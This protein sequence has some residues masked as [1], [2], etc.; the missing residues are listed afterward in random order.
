MASCV[1]SLLECG[2]CK[3]ASVVAPPYPTLPPPPLKLDIGCG[4]RKQAGFLGVDRIAFAGVDVV[5]DVSA[6]KWPW[7][8]STVDEIHASHFLEHLTASQRIHFINEA[9]RVLKPGG[10]AH[11]ITPHWC[12]NRAFGD[13]THQWPPVSEMWY[14]YLC[15]PWRKDNAPHNTEYVCDFEFPPVLGHSFHPAI[16]GRN[17]GYREL[18]QAWGK[19]AVLDLF[20]TLTAKKVG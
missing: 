4:T 13:L 16:A 18:A 6:D 17:D 12:S 9:W 2:E 5:M 20:A 1:H 3:R 11:I 8:D 10:K 7:P 14:S 19:E 15:I